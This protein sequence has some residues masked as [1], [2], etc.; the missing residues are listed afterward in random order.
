MRKAA[1][2]IL[3]KLL[4]ETGTDIK[5]QMRSEAELEDALG[6]TGRPREFAELLRILDGELRLITPADTADADDEQ[7]T[8]A[9]GGRYYQLTHDYLVQSL[10][11]WLTRKQRETRQG[12]AEL[13][14]VERS[15]IWN[16][17]PEN[18][19]LPSFVE[20]A[21]IRVLTKNEELD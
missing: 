5:G 20:W 21:N 3:K 9:R 11:V 6:T 4:P 2:A 15:A 1:R 16:T 13:L 19:H 14:L 7:P 18:R 17:R 8:A 10:R 12:R